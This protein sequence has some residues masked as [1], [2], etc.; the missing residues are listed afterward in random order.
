[1]GAAIVHYYYRKRKRTQKPDTRLIDVLKQALRFDKE[2]ENI[3]NDTSQ[4]IQE[5]SSSENDVCD[6]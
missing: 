5:I 1:M 3:A 6:E 4:I 2:E